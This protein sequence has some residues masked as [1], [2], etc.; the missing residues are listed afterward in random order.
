MTNERPSERVENWI[1]PSALD[2]SRTDRPALLDTRF[3]ESL[4]D[5]RPSDGWIKTVAVGGLPT[6]LGV[7]VVPTVLVAGYLVRVLRAT[8]HGDG[9]TG[10]ERPVV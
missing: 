6:L 7:L 5:L 3:T 9:E 1:L 8:M 10:T 4:T 2:P